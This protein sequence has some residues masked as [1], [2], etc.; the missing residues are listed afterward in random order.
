MTSYPYFG[1]TDLFFFTFEIKKL[2]LAVNII[3]SLPDEII[4]KSIDI[5]IKNQL[6]S[7]KKISLG[8]EKNI[9][10]ISLWM[11]IISDSKIDK[12]H[13]KINDLMQKKALPQITITHINHSESNSVFSFQLG[14]SSE[15]LDWH[16]KICEIVKPYASKKAATKAHFS[17]KEI[18]SSSLNY[19]NHFDEF[20][21]KEN[22]QPHITLGFGKHQKNDLKIQFTPTGMAT[23]HLGNYCSCSD[24]I[25]KFTP[26]M[27]AES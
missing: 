10:H 3:F 15:L 11:G 26:N 7:A 4:K 5:S 27:Q 2:E 8:F 25:K 1:I 22:F 23:Y 24:L 9:P 6:N 17:E 16:Y 19:L 18:H 13:Q 14:H 12:L 20:Y 21:S